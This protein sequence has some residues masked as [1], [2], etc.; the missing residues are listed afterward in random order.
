M[1]Q[2]WKVDPEYDAR[3]MRPW[4]NMLLKNVAMQRGDIQPCYLVHSIT[5]YWGQRYQYSVDSK[6]GSTAYAYM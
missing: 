5:H 4:V 1:G 3:K 6:K 2:L